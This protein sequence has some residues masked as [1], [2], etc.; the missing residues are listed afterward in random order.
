M[1]Q[2]D[3][4]SNAAFLRLICD[5]HDQAFKDSN[6]DSTRLSATKD[7][8][9]RPKYLFSVVE[10]LFSLRNVHQHMQKQKQ[11]SS[12]I[13][14]FVRKNYPFLLSHVWHV[15][16]HVE[17]HAC[18]HAWGCGSLATPG[19]LGLTRS[20]ARIL[21]RCCG[22]SRTS[23]APRCLSYTGPSGTTERHHQYW[24]LPRNFTLRARCALCLHG[25]CK[26]CEAGQFP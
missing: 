25:L 9:R 1:N 18:M 10:L 7:S 6:D 16:A 24:W 20:S 8:K 26:R 11:I 22:S 19:R 14:S 15:R 5:R 2:F 3:S 13:G 17:T 23:S 4:L 21:H 12:D